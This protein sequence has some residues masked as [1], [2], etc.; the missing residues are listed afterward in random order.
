MVDQLLQK[1]LSTSS[2][3]EAI[4]SLRMARKKY[5]G[6]TKSSTGSESSQSKDLAEMKQKYSHCY[7]QAHYWMNEAL[8]ARKENQRLS[9]Q[10]EDQKGVIQ[11]DSTASALL[12]F[13]FT[14]LLIIAFI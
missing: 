4:S 2:E 13:V 3:Q 8:D 10:L 12:G 9:K 5:A 6:G 14:L 11:L 7:R 1:A